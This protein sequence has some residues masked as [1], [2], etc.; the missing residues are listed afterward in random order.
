MKMNEQ[1]LVPYVYMAKTFE[2]DLFYVVQSQSIAIKCQKCTGYCASTSNVHHN[3]T[4][5]RLL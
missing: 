1:Y 4:K 5:V 3:H 2:T